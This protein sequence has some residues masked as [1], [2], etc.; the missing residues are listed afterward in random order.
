MAEGKSAPFSARDIYQ[1][2]DNDPVVF[3]ILHAKQDHPVILEG[4]QGAT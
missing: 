4:R 3:A 2:I 1:I